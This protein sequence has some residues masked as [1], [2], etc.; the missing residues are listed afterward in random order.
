V[1]IQLLN[2]AGQPA[3]QY[4]VHRAWVS[5]YL[6]LPDLDAGGNAIALEHIKLEH[7]GWEWDPSV[8]EPTEI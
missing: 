6:A 7:E 8:G 4:M 3:F 1:R 5:E 2:E